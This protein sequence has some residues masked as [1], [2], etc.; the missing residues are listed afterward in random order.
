MF[1]DFKLDNTIGTQGAISQTDFKKLLRLNEKNYF[2][3]P[4]EIQK[5]RGA[6]RVKTRKLRI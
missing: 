1:H 6:L 4:L 3:D 2:S 5:K